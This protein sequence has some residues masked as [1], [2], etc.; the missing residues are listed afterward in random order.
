MVLTQSEYQSLRVHIQD[1]KETLQGLERQ[2]TALA[3][4]RAADAHTDA[5]LVFA[6]AATVG[7]FND[8]LEE[9]EEKLGV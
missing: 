7:T 3:K 4:G 2:M 8:R 6:L 5:G 9:L 1:L